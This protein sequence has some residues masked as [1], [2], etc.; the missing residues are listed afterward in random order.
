VKFSRLLVVLFFFLPGF[1]V[2]ENLYFYVFFEGRPIQNADV[3]LD[4]AYLG[5]TDE[6]GNVSVDISPG[7]HTLS[8]GKNDIEI[9]T[10]VFENAAGEDV[11]ITVSTEATGD[12]QVAIEVF[13]DDLVSDAATGS[14][15]GIV[16]D[17]ENSP[18][19]GVSIFIMPANREVITNEQG[20]FEIELPRGE[21]SIQA[22][23]PEKG[24]ADATDIRI[25]SNVGTALELRLR[26][27]EGAV[28]EAATVDPNMEQV[29]VLGTYKPATTFSTIT[30]ERESFSVTDAIDIGQI[31]RF[32]DS[33]V[34]SAVKRVVGVALDDGKFA[35]I[36]G[37]K[38]RYVSSTLNG[39]LMPSTDPLR[40]DV[41]LDL[42]PSYILE[43]IEIQKSFSPDL[44]ADTTAGS[45]KMV[46]RGVPEDRI[47]KVSV[48]LGRSSSE[49][50]VTYQGGGDDDLGTDDG[51]RDLPG[52]INAATNGGLDFNVCDPAID[53]IRCTSPEDAADLAQQFRNIHAVQTESPDLN[54]G[55]AYAYG[56]RHEYNSGEWGYYGAIDYRRKWVSRENAFVDDIDGAWDYNQSDRQIDLS[57]YVVVGTELDSGHDLISKTM[58]LR[59]T[60]DTVL[61]EQG[62]NDEDVPFDQVILEW[63][64]REF[65]SQQFTGRHSLFEDHE[66][67]WRLTFSETTRYEPDRR[68]YLYLNDVFIASAYERSFSDLEEENTEFSIDYTLPFEFSSNISTDVKVGALLNTRSREVV[69]SR[70]GV[71]AGAGPALNLNND[72]E[73]I[74]GFDN[75]ENDS[76]RL[77]GRTADTD[78][79]EADQDITAL[80]VST[81]SEIGESLSLLIGARRESFE[82]ELRYPNSTDPSPPVIDDSD[83]LPTV[84]LNYRIGDSWQL[85]G[86]YSKTKSY[87]NII[88]RSDSLSYEPDTQK[89]IFGNPNLVS[90]DIDNF[91]IRLEYY[92]SDEESV[93]LG[94]F[95]KEIDNPI[96]RGIPDGSGSAANGITYRNNESAEVSGVEIDLNKDLIFTDN[97]EGFIAGNIAV[98][99]SE[100]ELSEEADRFEPES[101]DSRDLQGLIPLIVNVQFGLDHIPTEQKFTLLVNFLDERIDSVGRN[102]EPKIEEERL[103]LDF[104]YEKNFGDNYKLRAKLKNILDE[105]IEF[106]RAGRIVESYSEGTEFSLTLDVKI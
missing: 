60:E 94:F 92:F 46:T 81:E 87:P 63:V 20:A 4:G 53:P 76:V 89:A 85:R 26:A 50:V 40:R 23:H 29:V 15:A 83:L 93:S 106:S 52:A 43:G 84:S 51:T 17:T 100:I 21:Y 48:S 41:Q 11:E 82:Q 2:A 9:T 59:K 79:Y 13:S 22:R 32:G 103:S 10:T 44:P 14:L 80:Y 72:I 47:N 104:T 16:V 45:I 57:T 101:A 18:V 68:T 74:L 34:A 36:R 38:G 8:V 6:Q 99:D 98:T 88:E 39:S 35:V 66:L 7:S 90:S 31:A 19:P 64:E 71:R 28:Q 55:L 12:P 58:F 56:N 49:D 73:T 24:V 62:I 3:T 70:F 75:F 102:I 97:L 77:S 95:I 37:L 30:I 5:S 25:T 105:D 1:L 54:F 86:G 67:D 69:L 61:Q 78:T 33:S 27:A 91:D 96:E 65:F 42:F